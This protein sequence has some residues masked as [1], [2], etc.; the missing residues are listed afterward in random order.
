MDCYIGLNMAG[1]GLGGGTS[2]LFVC[3]DEMGT[4]MF[5]GHSDWKVRIL[6]G[7]PRP[8]ASCRSRNPAVKVMI[9]ISCTGR[10]HFSGVDR[11]YP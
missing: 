11:I 5:S 6:Q 9:P 7:A 3:T 4:A 10:I 2:P 1:G 8:C